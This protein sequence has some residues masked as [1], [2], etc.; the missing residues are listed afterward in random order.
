MGKMVGSKNFSHTG[1][2]GPGFVNVH[3]GMEAGVFLQGNTK[4][5]ALVHQLVEAI[6]SAFE[7]FREALYGLAEG[8]KST[9]LVRK[10]LLDRVSKGW[11]ENLSHFE[12]HLSHPEQ[13]RG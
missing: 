4:G 12:A 10:G 11:Q 5:F 8:Q 1:V 3:L 9:C 7:F 6:F 2:F 13:Q